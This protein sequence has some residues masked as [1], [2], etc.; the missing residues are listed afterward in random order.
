MT[1]PPPTPGG[2]GGRPVPD[3]ADLRILAELIN[4]DFVRLDDAAWR[5]R[6]S[7]REA[8][9]RL[10]T[11]AE[12]GMPLRLI[13]EGDRQALWRIAQAGP[14]TGAFQGPAPS[15]SG[16]VPVAVPV[17]VSVPQA[18]PDLAKPVPSPFPPADPPVAE[19]PV[20]ENAPFPPADPPVP[21]G[22]TP[23]PQPFADPV[24][25]QQ[26]TPVP[27]PF[28]DPAPPMPAPPLPAAPLPALSPAAIPPGVVPPTSP[29]PPHEQAIAGAV[30]LGEFPF[31]T[32]TSPE[33]T[34]TPAP[35]EDPAPEPA[36]EPAPTPAPL[37]AGAGTW[38]IPGTASWAR[39]DDPEPEPAAEPPAPAALQE[40]PGATQTWHFDEALPAAPPVPPAPAV[41]P[42]PAGPRI[43]DLAPLSMPPFVPPPLPSSGPTA[44]PDP[45]APRHAT[46][47]AAPSFPPLE[48]TG[49]FGERLTVSL[50][51]VIDPADEILS[52][53]GYRMDGTERAVLVRTA[54]HNAG[55]IDHESLPDLY[56]VL[57]GFDGRPLPKAPMSVP[58]HPAHQVG[59]AAGATSTGWTLFLLPPP[60]MV[61]AVRWSV[62]PDL[63]QHTLEW[64]V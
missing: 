36:P 13:A 58:G 27:Q 3:T 42:V 55:P 41:P 51:D 24:P 50:L 46:P 52:N 34:E 62:R 6:M 9:D 61:A 56:L 54:V 64:R 4:N 17:P 11:M 14:V 44:V 19:A 38:G 8:V 21:A 57:I 2:P 37:P 29:V 59:I 63:T 39:A 22:F 7:P 48:T 28:A 5:A 31:G 26:F 1:T 60:V 32:P 35:A 16:P 40:D 25:P 43:P 10:L 23:V 18:A 45:A 47:P 20:P 53:A 49:L 15:P 33:G 30:P 12:R